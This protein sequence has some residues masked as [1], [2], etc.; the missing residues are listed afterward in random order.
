MCPNVGGRDYT[1][2]C[3]NCTHKLSVHVLTNP[4][5]EASTGGGNQEERG[6]EEERRRKGG[7]EKRRSRVRGGGGGEQRRRR[8]AEEEEGSRG[9]G[10]EQRRRRGV[11]EEERRGGNISTHWPLH[12]LQTLHPT[13]HTL[14]S[15]TS[16]PHSTKP[17]SLLSCCLGTRQTHT[18]SHTWMR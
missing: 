5:T 7:G 12:Q 2:M 10:G 16:H 15:K 1:R 13:S 11:E 8:G 18:N 6:A 4:L 3:P 9:G 14:E 17:F